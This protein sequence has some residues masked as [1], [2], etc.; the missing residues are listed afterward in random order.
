MRWKQKVRPDLRYEWH[1]WFAWHPVNVAGF[2]A[3]PGTFVW[4]ETVERRLCENE[5][6]DD[7]WQ[8]RDISMPEAA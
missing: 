7:Y 5:R 3:Y 6:S 1:R 4:L 8:Y 2:N